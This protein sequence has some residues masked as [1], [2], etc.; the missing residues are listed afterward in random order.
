MKALLL[1]LAVASAACGPMH[2]NVRVVSDISVV[3]TNFVVET[4]DVNPKR[5][6]EDCRT[7]STPIPVYAVPAPPPA[8]RDLAFTI[9]HADIAAKLSAARAA[10]DACALTSK[11]TEPLRIRLE[12]DGSGQVIGATLPDQGDAE[13]AGCI[14][15]ALASVKFTVASQGLVYTFRPEAR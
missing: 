4:C 13:L 5:G 14:D 9:E 12:I 3:G 7:A 15:A 2:R 10:V 1:G 6:N 11:R 8:K